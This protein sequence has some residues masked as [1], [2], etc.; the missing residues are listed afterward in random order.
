MMQIVSIDLVRGLVNTDHGC[1][2]ISTMLD[3]IGEETSSPVEAEQ[4]IMHVPKCVAVF[5]EGQ[6]LR[7]DLALFKLPTLH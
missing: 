3:C 6:W 1:L 5:A 4:I 7:I 2:Y